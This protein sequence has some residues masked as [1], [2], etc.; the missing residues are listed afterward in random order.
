MPVHNVK[1][2][3]DIN[4]LIPPMSNIDNS[5]YLI[6]TSSEAEAITIRYGLASGE[7]ATPN[8]RTELYH[9]VRWSGETPIYSL[10]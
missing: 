4:Y 3:I 1:Q 5:K 2:D 9:L 8:M 7:L 10:K 6:Q